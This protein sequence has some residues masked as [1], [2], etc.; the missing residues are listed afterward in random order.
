MMMMIIITPIIAYSDLPNTYS[1]DIPNGSCNISIFVDGKYEMWID[2]WYG[3]IGGGFTISSGKYQIK[4][5]ILVLIDS[6][7]QFEMKFIF[8]NRFLIPE[9][10]FIFAKDI[11]FEFF[12]S[13][14]DSVS[15]FSDIPNAN[16]ITKKK[17]T[18][19]KTVKYELHL[20]KYI[21]EGD[22]YS[23]Y[24]NINSN[25]SF[26][27]KVEDLTLLSG[28]WERKGNELRLYDTTLKHTFFVFI[29]K[30]KL[31]NYIFNEQIGREYFKVKTN[32]KVKK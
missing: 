11:K 14:T 30:N 8:K 18:N 2:Q 32:K 7:N 29:A 27:L 6:Y 25:Q 22:L 23:W 10:S 13:P 31:I 17:F 20:G 3:D 24:F 19:T 5:N 12:D 28:T 4:K 1:V 16:E 9:K 26:E 21:G 15:T